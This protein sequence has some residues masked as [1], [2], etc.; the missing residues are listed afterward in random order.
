[1][2]EALVRLNNE[3]GLTCPREEL[4]G[5][6]W[7]KLLPPPTQQDLST[8]SINQLILLL[9]LLPLGQKIVNIVAMH[10]CLSPFSVCL[11]LSQS[12]TTIILNAASG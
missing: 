7:R 4:S 5:P 8:L 9:L 11:S 12:H 3:G 1:M 2:E 6:L 10:L